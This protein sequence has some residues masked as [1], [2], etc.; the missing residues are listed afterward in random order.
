VPAPRAPLSAQILADRDL[1]ISLALEGWA[2]ALSSLQA[3]LDGLGEQLGRALGTMR[4][5]S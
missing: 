1:T 4:E 2:R 5:L 3:A